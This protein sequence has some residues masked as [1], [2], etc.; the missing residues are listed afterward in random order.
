M[1]VKELTSFVTLFDTNIDR[2]CKFVTLN[3][4]KKKMNQ[5]FLMKI[6]QLLN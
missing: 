4:T 2:N 1:Y 5:R 3:Y 6:N